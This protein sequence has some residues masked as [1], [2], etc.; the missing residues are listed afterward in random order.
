MKSDLLEALRKGGF[1]MI[2]DEEDETS[3]RY[4]VKINDDVGKD[5]L[6]EIALNFLE[7]EEFEVGDFVTL[8]DFCSLYKNPP[9]GCVAVVVALHPGATDESQ[10]SGTPFY[11]AP[12]DVEI[13]FLDSD[14][15]FQTSR[16]DGR[17]LRKVK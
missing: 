5:R 13:G 1:S 16:M 12:L 15:D 8:K 11:R 10:P 2:S 9:P 7:R 3:N 6:R 14:G 4:A 17:R